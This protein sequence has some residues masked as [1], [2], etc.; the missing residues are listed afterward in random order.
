MCLGLYCLIF[1]HAN[2]AT[3][4]SFSILTFLDLGDATNPGL[5]NS[6]LYEHCPVPHLTSITGTTVSLLTS[7]S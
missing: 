6:L 4:N 1:L 2:T 5:H 7:V 3:R